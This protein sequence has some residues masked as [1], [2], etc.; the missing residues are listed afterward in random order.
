MR[1]LLTGG[2]GFIGSHFA[3]MASRQGHHL[4]ILDAMTYAARPANL[5][6]VKP[7]T[8]FRGDVANPK[9]VRCA[10]EGFEPEWIVHMA[11]ETHVGRSL[12]DREAF[13]R[14][15]VV[16]TDVMLNE[17]HE[18]WK[19]TGRHPDF[20]FLHVST[21]EVYGSLR[22][23]ELPWTEASAYAPNNPYSASKAASDHL[24]RAYNA[25]WGFPTIIT[26]SSNN[27][28]PAQHPEKLIPVLLNQCMQGVPMTLHGDGMNVRDWLHVEDHCRGLLRAL[29]R[30]L[31]GETYNFG[32]VC[33]RTNREIAHLVWTVVNNTGT[34]QAPAGRLHFVTDRPGNDRRYAVDVKKARMALDWWPGA[35]IEKHLPSVARWYAENPNYADQYESAA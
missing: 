26:H 9:D 3:R 34:V 18:W 5:E 4:Y 24:V 8:A 35:S 31:P 12:E 2:M 1:I 32:G 22:T 23:F 15:N 29:E 33:E 20:R 25:S 21:D 10:L 30:G 7:V 16:G 6:D 17:C 14:T 11:A 27:Y 19:A 28:G 13:L